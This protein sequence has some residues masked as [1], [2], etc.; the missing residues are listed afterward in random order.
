MRL[1]DQS[2]SCEVLSEDEEFVLSLLREIMGELRARGH[3]ADVK[4]MEMAIV[5]A[6]AQIERV[7]PGLEFQVFRIRSARFLVQARAG[8]NGAIE[9]MF[10]KVE[11]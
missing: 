9:L 11:S 7:A 1:E 4:S 5:N 3:A 10:I 8:Q 2:D 6:G